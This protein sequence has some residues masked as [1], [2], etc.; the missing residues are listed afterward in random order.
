MNSQVADAKLLKQRVN[1]LKKLIITGLKTEIK[2]IKDTKK[3]ASEN[4]LKALREEIKKQHAAIVA[5]RLALSDLTY[6]YIQAFPHSSAR[7]LRKLHYQTAEGYLADM[8]IGE[9]PDLQE[10]LELIINK[11]AYIPAF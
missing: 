7:L 11:F 5:Y 4:D 8:A 9:M 3:A 10:M 1:S 2:L 6:A